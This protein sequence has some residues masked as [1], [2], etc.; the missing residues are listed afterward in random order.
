MHD[1]GSQKAATEIK[2]LQTKIKKPDWASG[3]WMLFASSQ[4]DLE[5]RA[6]FN[7][8]AE[9]FLGVHRAG[10]GQARGFRVC[11]PKGQWLQA[12]A[13]SRSIV[14]GGW[15][16]ERLVVVG[17]DI[18]RSETTQVSGDNRDRLLQHQTNTEHTVCGPTLLQEHRLQLSLVGHTTC[19]A[20]G[21]EAPGS[22]ICQGAGALS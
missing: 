11:L 18:S 10:L 20:H 5:K 3:S 15:Q 14:C 21:P 1:S 12:P 17:L 2:K 4:A 22:Q 8:R 6:N 13:Q 9:Q 16:G 19:G 7:M